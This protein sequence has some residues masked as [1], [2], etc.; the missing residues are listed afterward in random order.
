MKPEIKYIDIV[1]HSAL[2]YSNQNPY[3]LKEKEI[4][5]LHK[6]DIVADESEKKRNK[7]KFNWTITRN[8]YLYDYLKRWDKAECELVFNCILNGSVDVCGMAYDMS[9]LL[10]EE[11]AVKTA[12]WLPDDIREKL[13]ISSVMFRGVGGVSSSSMIHAS[14]R[15]VK[16]L[17]AELSPNVLR[18]IKTPPFLF[19]WKL[20]KTEKVLVFLSDFS[21]SFETLLQ[22]DGNV[23]YLSLIHI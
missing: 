20:S 22:N 15:G 18:N 4:K 13:N 10:S 1:C 2:G 14:K 19:S 5:K 9:S 21:K 11:Q 17:W 3:A 12:S 16:Y 7:T 6:A 8:S 23:R